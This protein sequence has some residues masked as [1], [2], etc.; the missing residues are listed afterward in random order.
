MWPITL[1]T[2]PTSICGPWYY[3]GGPQVLKE[4]HKQLTHPKRM[5]GLVTPGIIL[6]VTLLATTVVLS[7][8]P[9]PECTN[10]TFCQLSGK[11]YT[12]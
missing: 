11:K 12:I 1:V 10:Y 4:I 9:S 8:A 2:I 7:E 5:V 6:L 3:D